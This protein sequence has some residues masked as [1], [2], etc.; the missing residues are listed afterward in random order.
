M[1]ASNTNSFL[2]C[3]RWGS[4]RT[5]SLYFDVT[6]LRQ[7][8]VILRNLVALGEIGI[9]IILA[10]EDRGLANLA[11]QRHGSEYRKFHRLAVQNRQCSRMAQAHGTDIGIGRIAEAR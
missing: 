6:M 11:L 4:R 8:P 5:L 7:R 9:K 3:H 2:G 10:R 1:D